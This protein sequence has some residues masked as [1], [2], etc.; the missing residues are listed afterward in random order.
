MQ[1]DVAKSEAAQ[2]QRS[3]QQAQKHQAEATAAFVASLQS[4]VRNILAGGEQHRFE[5]MR[6]MLFHIG[7]K[8]SHVIQVCSS[9]AADIKCHS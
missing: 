8:A 9:H 4:K 1:L 2:G 6:R 7:H 3:M 5:S